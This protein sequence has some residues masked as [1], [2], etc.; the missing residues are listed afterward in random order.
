MRA[1][2]LMAVT[3]EWMQAPTLGQTVVR[4]LGRTRVRSLCEASPDA[5]LCVPGVPSDLDDI[6]T[7]APSFSIGGIVS[8]DLNG[9]GLLDLVSVKFAGYG[10]GAD[11]NVF[12][13][14]PD[15]G[16]T[17]P[18]PYQGVTGDGLAVGDLNGDGFPD[19][20]VSNGG[21]I[22]LLANDGTGKLTPFT[23][24]TT[25]STLTADEVAIVDL[26]G[27]G[28]ADVL[29]SVFLEGLASDLE[30]FW[31]QSDGTFSGPFVVA[32]IGGNGFAIFAVGDLNQDCLPDIVANSPDFTRLAVM[33]NQ[34]D[35]G[36]QT[37]LYPIPAL[38][39]IALL[40]NARGAPDLL[41]GVTGYDFESK[42]VQNGTQLF[43]NQGDGTF[44]IGPDYQVGG[45]WVSVGDFNGDCIP[46]IAT[47][48]NTDCS[49]YW[50]GTILFGEADGGFG[51][52]KQLKTAGIHRGRPVL[53]GLVESP[54]ALAVGEVVEPASPSTATRAS[55]GNR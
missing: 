10:G 31:G 47:S 53:L 43:W 45:V 17:A 23:S 41:V 26:N 21:Q 18:T 46:D 12:F 38:G 6:A 39:T 29:A 32:T 13:G 55:T 52:P 19:V 1:L 14:Q 3:Q 44:V 51:D 27:D 54:R 30:V 35:G 22:S 49:G 28:F 15:G 48:V 4:M 40:P 16:L 11:L 42:L 50:E 5:G 33:L 25:N 37:T 24:L 7:Y 8:S 34:A 9:D 20:A 2:M 36:F